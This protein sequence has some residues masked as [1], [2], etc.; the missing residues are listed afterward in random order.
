MLS[1]LL[2][3][4]D[5]AA[6]N[7]ISNGQME[8]RVPEGLSKVLEFQNNDKVL[9]PCFAQDAIEFLMHLFIPTSRKL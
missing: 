9:H 6:C 1:E 8:K 2:I 5:T 3:Q 7:A 4:M